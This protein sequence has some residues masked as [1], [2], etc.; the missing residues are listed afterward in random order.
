MKADSRF[1]IPRSAFGHFAVFP[2]PCPD[3][4]WGTLHLMVDPRLQPIPSFERYTFI[5]SFIQS[6]LGQMVM[7]SVLCVK[8]GKPARHRVKS[9]SYTG[10]LNLYVLKWPEMAFWQLSNGITRVSPFRSFLS[11]LHC[12]PAIVLKEHNCDQQP[13]SW[14]IIWYVAI[15]GSTFPRARVAGSGWRVAGGGWQVAG[16]GLYHLLHQFL[17][18]NLF[19]H[20]SKMYKVN[21]GMLVVT[22]S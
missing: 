6:W 2:L 19:S 13:T 17:I 3:I 18:T 11:K 4:D 10:P 15:D 8:F 14:S 12:P 1:P 7:L 21:I 9:T 16:D 5:H 22:P 20:F